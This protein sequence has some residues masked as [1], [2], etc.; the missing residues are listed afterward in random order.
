MRFKFEIETHDPREAEAL[1]KGIAEVGETSEPP[2]P[3]T[4]LTDDE[5]GAAQGA[6]ATQVAIAL[7]LLAQIPDITTVETDEHRAILRDVLTYV[8]LAGINARD[9]L[10]NTPEKTCVYACAPINHCTVPDIIKAAAK[11]AKE[12]NDAANAAFE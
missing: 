11:A 3:K 4:P 5:I 9:V 2:T 12:A 7:V 10:N 8:S 1:A 6:I